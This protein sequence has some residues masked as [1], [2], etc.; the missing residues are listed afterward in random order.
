[1]QVSNFN[2]SVIGQP[3]AEGPEL[4]ERDWTFQCLGFRLAGSVLLGETAPPHKV[5]RAKEPSR[6]PIHMGWRAGWIQVSV[7][8]WYWALYRSPGGKEAWLQTWPGYEA[9]DNADREAT[10]IYY[11]LKW[12][13]Y[14]ELSKSSPLALLKFVD[15][16]IAAFPPTIADP[17]GGQSVLANIGVRLSFVCALA[18]RDPDDAV[19]VTQWVPWYVQW[20][21]DFKLGAAELEPRPVR[22]KTKALCG[23]ARHGAPEI[24][25]RAI[26]ASWGQKSAN[27][28]ATFDKPALRRLAGPQIEAE[29]GR[30]RRLAE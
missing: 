7:Q 23:K 24:L 19:Y 3:R 25:I 17:G 9:I 1:M 18:A 12:P 27:Y 30:L 14:Q 29:L 16:P 20:M 22:D 4:L 13:F 10:D 28:H 2:L 6:S 15:L 8:E 26:A 5:T 21:C 11:N